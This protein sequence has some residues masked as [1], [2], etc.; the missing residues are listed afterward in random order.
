MLL[1]DVNVLL[2][3]HRVDHPAHDTLSAWVTARLSDAEPFG[4]SELVLSSVVRIATNRRAFPAP[5]TPEE[6][7]DFCAALLAGRSSVVVAP[8]RRHWEIFDRLVRTVHAT[9]NLIP[10]AY[11]AALAIENGATFVTLDRGFARFPGL[12]LMDPLAA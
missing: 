9:A 7:L 8:G 10:D 5:A 4:I 11:Y 1:C 3:A 2:G 6:A 12:R